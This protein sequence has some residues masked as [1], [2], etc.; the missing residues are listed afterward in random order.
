MALEKQTKL[1]EFTIRSDGSISV[2]LEKVVVDG[3]EIVAGGQYHRASLFPGQDI[4]AYSAAVDS[5]LQEL[6]YPAAP[7]DVWAK[8]RGYAQSE[9]TP[10]VISAYAASLSA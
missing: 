8:V 5:Q 3:P 10:A 6:G 7:P 1:V 9:W 4:D 2:R